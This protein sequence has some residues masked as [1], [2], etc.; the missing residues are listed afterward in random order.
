MNLVE[1]SMEFQED[2]YFVDGS[3]LTELDVI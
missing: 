1:Y 3:T 2:T